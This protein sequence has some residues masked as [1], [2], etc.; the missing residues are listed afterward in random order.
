M[1]SDRA[2]STADYLKDNSRGGGAA[3]LALSRRRFAWTRHGWHLAFAVVMLSYTVTKLAVIFG[4]IGY[5]AGWGE[6]WGLMS[7]S[8]HLTLLAG[9]RFADEGFLAN[10]F[11]SNMSVG[12]KD[13]ARGWVEFQVPP[14]VPNSRMYYTHYGSLDSLFAGALMKLGVRDLTT[15]YVIVQLLSMTTLAV[16]YAAL[17]RVFSPLVGFF[18]GVTV[19][20]AP[21]FW[22]QAESISAEGLALSITFVGASAALIALATPRALGRPTWLLVVAFAACFLSAHNNPIPVGA[23]GMSIASMVVIGV[24][25]LWPRVKRVFI[26]CTGFIFGYG[27]HFAKSVWVLG[28]LEN[29]KV[30]MAA[31]VAR[32]TTQFEQAVEVHVRNF[33]M[34]MALQYLQ[35]R[36]KEMFGYSYWS[37]AVF[38]AVLGGIVLVL[39]WR[40]RS[41]A[42]TKPVV[43]G[44]FVLAGG[45]IFPA[46]F[47]Q[48]AMSQ[49]I[50]VTKAIIPGLALLVGASV[51]QTVALVRL[52]S[53]APMSRTFIVILAI[54][55]MLPTVAATVNTPRFVWKQYWARPI[56][57]YAG[58]TP[59]EIDEIAAFLASSTKP[60]DIVF[61]EVA[62]GWT[63]ML[64]YP[65]PAWEYRSGRRIEPVANLAQFETRL[66]K[67]NKEILGVPRDHAG[68]DAHVFLLA[69]GDI[70]QSFLDRIASSH[71]TVVG[72]RDTSRTTGGTRRL[73]LYQID[74]AAIIQERLDGDAPF[75]AEPESMTPW[76][77]VEPFETEEPEVGKPALGFAQSS[78]HFDGG[79]LLFDTLGD[80]DDCADHCGIHWRLNEDAVEF[81]AEIRVRLDRVV[82]RPGSL[83]GG[84][85]VLSSADHEAG[86]YFGDDLIR[87][88]VDKTI[89]GSVPFRP[90][91]TYRLRITLW[92]G[93]F[94]AY[95]DDRLVVKERGSPGVVSRPSA[96]TFGDYFKASGV[97]IVG[98]LDYFAVSDRGAFAPG[99]IREM[100]Q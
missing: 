14:L 22:L 73:T 50:D 19:L 15:F 20:L 100:S 38:L 13:L 64:N 16:W 33:N 84:L 67:V 70:E 23:L 37:F 8:D 28:G 94:A 26:V 11:T 48:A 24:G 93:W 41:L 7:F 55:A 46:L 42:E 17:C 43:Y 98:A 5:P 72:T 71:G 44:L 97:G 75:R 90:G 4:W 49:P 89:R 96:A 45:L 27:T 65:H 29:W 59:R 25:P 74:A 81:T 6:W 54:V 12:A 91:K 78:M 68:H 3:D 63:G 60:Q 76:Y 53:V 56:T 58:T 34:D 9:K 79:A 39:A 92:P 86:F 18:A 62:T 47:L 61:S 2:T 87:V 95:V 66:K 80:G 51:H 30:D 40:R 88:I 82:A 32:R 1:T 69:N 36:V 99:G 52:P 35:M 57:D 83:G 77:R 85:F 21:A 31:A 10:Y